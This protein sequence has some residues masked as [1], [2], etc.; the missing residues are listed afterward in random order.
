MRAEDRRLSH[1]YKKWDVTLTLLLV[2]Y[3]KGDFG[4]LEHY[5][6]LVAVSGALGV[7][8]ADLKISEVSESPKYPNQ[9]LITCDIRT[10]DRQL[11]ALVEGD[12]SSAGQKNELTDSILDEMKTTGLNA[13]T[14]SIINVDAPN[15]IAPQSPERTGGVHRN[16]LDD[17]HLKGMGTTRGNIF[18]LW[19][20]MLVAFVGGESLSIS[21]SHGIVMLCA[22]SQMFV[23]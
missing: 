23:M 11:I 15:S 18:F 4:K 8:Q 9:L 12:V 21:C 1:D 22:G 16:D 7:P 20:L 14:V 17:S 10:S 6:F 3:S 19:M 2:G 5:N 13:E